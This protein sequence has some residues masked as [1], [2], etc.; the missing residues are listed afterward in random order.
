M[1]PMEQAEA[2]MVRKE[3]EN[4]RDLESAIGLEHFL[5]RRDLSDRGTLDS[6]L[7]CAL[8]LYYVL[9]L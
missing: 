3:E 7:C 4:R 5:E 2:E 9:F 8:L 6:V 1:D